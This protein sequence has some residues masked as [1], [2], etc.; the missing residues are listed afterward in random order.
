MEHKHLLGVFYH[1]DGR[2]DVAFLFVQQAQLKHGKWYQI[3]V[4]FDIIFAAKR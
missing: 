3:I 4:M 2:V 1:G